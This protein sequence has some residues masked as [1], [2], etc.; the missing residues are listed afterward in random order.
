LNGEIFGTP[1]TATLEK[2]VK[3]GGSGI[4]VSISPIYIDGFM[5]QFQS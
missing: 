4:T 5:G 3:I 2:M 1:N